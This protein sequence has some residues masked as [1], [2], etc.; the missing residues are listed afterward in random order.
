MK[1]KGTGMRWIVLT[2]VLIS[3]VIAGMGRTPAVSGNEAGRSAPGNGIVFSMTNEQITNKVFAYSRAS[4]GKLS[5][6][7]SYPTMG[8]GTGADLN[9]QGA[10]LLLPIQKLLYVV[11]PKSGTITEFTVS[12][13]GLTFVGLT[14]TGGKMPTS[15]GAYGRVIYSLNAAAQTITGFTI[16]LQGKLA[17]IP[18]A[19][20]LLNPAPKSAPVQVSFTPSG[21][22]IVVTQMKANII[23]VFPV[24]ANGTVGTAVFQTSNGAGPFGFAFDQNGNLDDTESSNA[25]NGLSSYAIQSD[26]TLQ[27]LSGSV[28]DGG[29]EASHIVDVYVP[30]LGMQV[31]YVANAITN[32]ISSYS[33]QADGT[34]SLMNPVAAQFAASVKLIDMSLDS[35]GSYLYALTQ[36]TG[37]ITGFAINPDGSLTKIT[38]GT[39]LPTKGTWGLAAD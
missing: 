10:L 18:G 19:M 39:G 3:A 20:G 1:T 2:G 33:I 35:S 36:K 24:N 12:S 15:L 22:Q 23:D 26:G 17:A 38:E 16:G 13:H 21:K 29:M 11:N 14:N 4:D 27:V 9:S 30:G 37:T 25:L 31:A 7:G 28:Q 6:L 34:V 32:A 8:G 5:F